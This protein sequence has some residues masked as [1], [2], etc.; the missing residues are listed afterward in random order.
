MT[1][2]SGLDEKIHSAPGNVPVSGRRGM[3]SAPCPET[4]APGIAFKGGV[5][6]LPLGIG[7]GRA[8]E[9][10]ERRTD[11]ADGPDLLKFSPESGIQKP[12]FRAEKS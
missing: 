7:E 2:L 3:F 12:V 5:R 1:E 6:A 8:P 4:A 9:G 10:V 11:D